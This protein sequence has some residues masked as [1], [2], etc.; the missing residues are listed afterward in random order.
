ME[1]SGINNVLSSFILILLGLGTQGFVFFYYLNNLKNIDC[2]C[3]DDKFHE[4]IKQYF[5]LTLLSCILL[6]SCYL[7]HANA[8]LLNVV[9]TFFIFS[10]IMLMYNIRHMLVHIRKYSCNCAESMVKEIIDIINILEISFYVIT[11]V[12]IIVLMFMN[13][14]DY[15]SQ[16]C[17]H[18]MGNNDFDK[19]YITNIRARP[20]YH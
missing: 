12:S 14:N 6:Y 18:N 17:M 13:I 20:H 1:S 7:L 11:I 10:H 5:K 8:F 15:N 9:R 2:N 16:P 19:I 3:V 4:S